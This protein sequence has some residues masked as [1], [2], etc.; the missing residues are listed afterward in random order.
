MTRHGLNHTRA[1]A[2][3]L[4]PSANLV[5]ATSNTYPMLPFSQYPGAQ[6]LRTSHQCGNQ[7]A[8]HAGHA[9]GQ[10]TPKRD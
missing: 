1:A 5:S 6:N 10:P 8:R 7:A 2:I 4:L 3:A 9:V